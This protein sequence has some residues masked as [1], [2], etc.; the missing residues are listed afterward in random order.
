MITVTADPAGLDRDVLAGTLRAAAGVGQLAGVVSLLALDGTDRAGVPAG[1]TGSL[2]LVQALGDARIGARLWAVTSGAVSAGEPVPVSVSQAMVWGLGRVAA[3]EHPDRWGGLI[4]IPATVTG[5]VAA[6]LREILSGRTGEDQV[7]VRPGGVLARRLIRAPAAPPPAVRAATRWR[8]SGAVLVTGG[9]GALG[10]RVARWAVGRG[11]PHVILASRRGIGA[12]GAAGLAAVLCGAGAAVTVAACDAADRAD[13]DGL[14]ARLTGAGIAVRAVMHAAGAPQSTA[15][16]DVSLAEF[17]A[18]SGAKTV[19]ALLLDEH[20]GAE[21]EAFALFSSV[22]ATWGSSGQA[23]Y[24]A[25]NAALDALAEDRRARGLAATSVAWGPWD[26]GGMGEG[27]AGQQLR[28]RGLR[29]MS[30]RLAVAALGQ[31]LDLGETGLAVADM[32]W[33]RFVPAFTIARPSPLLAGLDEVRQL[34]EADRTRPSQGAGR[35][36]LAERLSGLSAGE[37]EQLVLDLVCR[38][39]ASVLGHESA[40]AVRPGAVFRDLGFDSLTAVDLRDRLTAVT[41]LRLPATLVFDYPSPLVLAEWLRAQITGVQAATVTVTPGAVTGDPVAVV[42]MGCRFPGGVASPEDLWELVR[43]GTDAVSGFPADRGWDSG[44]GGD[45]YARLGGFVY[46]AAEFDAGFFGISPRE[47][48][49]MDPQQRLLL[50]VCWEA[51]ERAGMDPRAL[52]GS[53]TAVFVGV[54]SPDYPTLLAQAADGAEGHLLTGNLV[55]VVSGRVSYALGLEGPA[56]SVDTACSSALVALH[57]ACQALRAGEC[58]LAL[59]GGVAV[60]ATPTVFAQFSVQGGLAAD[61]RCKAFGAGADGTGWAEGAGVL[62]VERLSDA[63]RLG[64]PVLAVVAGSAVNQDGA[65]NGLTAPNGPSQQRV[66]RAALAAA[67]LSPDQVDVVEGH[68]TGTVLGDP[69]EAQALLAAYGQGRDAERPLWLGSVKS[70][71]GHSQAAAGTAGVIKMVMALRHQVLPPTLHASEPSS[72]VDWS[73]GTVRLLTE[74]QDWPDAEGRPRRAGVSSFGISG[75]N[76]HVI[77]EGA[78]VLPSSPETGFWGGDGGTNGGDGGTHT[79]QPPARPFGLRGPVPW[80]VSGRGEAG[81]RAQAE[82]LAAYLT[83]QPDLHPVDVGWSLVS[84]RSV[85]E[86]RAVVLARD[87]AGFAAGLQAVAGGVPAAGVIEGR[88][89]GST[90]KVAFVFA[91]Q[92]SQRTGMGQAL[93]RE[94]PVFADAV[95]EVCGYLDPLLGLDVAEAVF[96][97]PG[98][99]AAGA[100]DQT[101]LTQA[102]MFAVQVGLARLLRSWG[103]APDYV[104]GHSI[105][106]IAA[107]HVAGMLSLEDACALV[108][109]RGR[110]MQELGGGGA[111]AAV[112]APEAEVTAWLAEAGITDAVVAA[113]NGPRS[114]VVSGEAGSVAEAGRFWRGQGVRVRRL[115]TSHAFHS[116]LVEPMLA[117]LGE[118]AAGLSFQEPQVPVVCS[119][120]GQPDAELMGTPGYWVRQAREAVRFADCVR[121][122]AGTGAGIFTELGVDGALSALGPAIQGDGGSA[123]GSEWVPV[124]RAGRPEPE[125]ALTAAAE[126]FVRGAPVDWAGAFAGSDARRVGLPTYAFQRQRFWPVLHPMA[127][128]LQ[129]AGGDGAEAGFWAAVERQDLSGVADTL[130]VSGDEPLSAVL[131][132]LAAWRRRNREQS[133]LDRWRYQVSWVPVTGLGDGVM[134]SGRWLLVVPAGLAGTRLAAT[135]GRVLG[136]GGAQVMT[137]KVGR[138][139]LD[140]GVLAGTLRAVAG[141]KGAAGVVSLLALDEV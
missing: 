2:V 140:R 45:G 95:A 88:T 53:R 100:V 22:S 12:A 10:G 51:I 17:A 37:Q 57:L 11:A 63:R 138:A 41:G 62:L 131:P 105:G 1:V 112:A 89:D 34:M 19:G 102:G 90:A 96:A 66:I 25:A 35:G 71:I 52:R 104:T 84:G 124:L 40:E 77:I 83:R 6:W 47:A 121:W 21:V 130:Q 115:R 59:A 128:M 107:A 99:A 87:A 27:V 29:S 85:F 14:W 67:A 79:V 5:R 24:A 127:A 8:P 141:G 114:V 69:I 97:G 3:L 46:E 106:E 117:G 80:V 101:V 72:H 75:T 139:D 82:R 38:E 65:S 73:S 81:L 125:A 61:G 16:A 9:T 137:V 132:V 18:V 93:A 110:G 122:L 60:M 15:L 13:L 119:V 78:P 91:G 28:R 123:E 111:M 129:V 120:T 49:A 92:G 135:C 116:P 42:A 98:T 68:G 64:H 86:D 26:G 118:V 126:L 39:A 7:A 48:L 109:A 133:V 74:A 108:A 113:V 30:P 94:F 20:A 44:P 31:A 32:D 58:D 55:S 54:S 76:A 56:V 103:I 43:S 36:L 134:L 70:N 23:A 136:D 50:E 33:Q 4:D